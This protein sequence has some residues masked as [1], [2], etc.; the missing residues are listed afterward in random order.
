[1][2]DAVRWFVVLEILGV[3]FLPLTVWLLGS[4][5]DHGY[6]S[7]K[8]LGLLAVTYL[9]WL[10]GSFI[11]I[12][13][14]ALLPLVVVLVAAALGWWFWLDRT[15]DAVRPLRRVIAVE[16]AVFL[17]GFV[18]WCLLRAFVLH[19]GISHTEQPM[20]MALLNAS[21]H[22]ASYP[23]YDPWMSGHTINYYYLGYLLFAMPAK[24]SGVAPTVAYN[25]ALST[26]P[27][28]LMSSCYG[29][30]YAFVR[31]L[32][33]PLLAPLFVAVIGNWHAA[34]AQIPQGQTP[35]NT[36]WWFWCS[37]RV[38]GPS[39]DS[40]TTITEFPFFSFLLGDLHPHVMTLPL[41][42]LAITIGCAILFSEERIAVERRVQPLARLVCASVAV[43]IL[44]TANSWDFP[45]YLLFV[46]SCIV[47]N[48]YLHDDSTTWYQSA[49][50]SAAVLAVASVV[51]FA[52]FYLHY[53]SVTHGI[54]LVNTPSDFWQFLQ[55][56]GLFL[57]LAA[58]FVGILS[59]LLQPDDAS[60]EGED[61]SQT[62]ATAS[63]AGEARTWAASNGW[64]IVL[65]A[66]I[67]VLGV[68]FHLVVL[69]ALLGVGM[70]AVLLLY[71]VL[72]TETP[73]RGDACALLLVAAGCLAA[74][75]PEVVYLRD[76]FDG[77]A[78]YRMN[79]IFK[80]DYQAW[81]LLGLAA[82]YAVYR[83]WHIVRALF[84]PALGWLVLGCAMVGTIMGLAYTWIAPPTAYTA[85]AATSLDAL[86]SLSPHNPGD[87]DM[88][89]WLDAHA[90]PGAVEAEALG[91][92][93]HQNEEY[94]ADIGRIS[95]YTGLSAVLAWPGHER[96]WRGDD[97]E[98]TARE[99]DVNTIFSTKEVATAR[100][101][102]HK[103]NVRYV[104]VGDS[105]R[106]M[107]GSDPAALAKFSRFM[108][109]AY[110][111]SSLSQGSSSTDTIYTW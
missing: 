34:L 71:R 9:T 20:D 55:V 59:V 107:Y 11:P 4:L 74:A 28:L 60:S 48:A 65:F 57:I 93:Q 31:K 54:G 29:I 80:F 49:A 77:G 61:W 46:G 75:I 56:L 10:V 66:A 69:L 37:T 91:N 97:P 17:A 12:A 39:C 89:R 98:I 25:L 14:S 96:Q 44:F 42:A 64:S 51:L 104:I 23:A 81:V 21:I 79:T 16:E 105:E 95:F 47:I 84:A 43:G 53:R 73:N 100:R 106:T 58:A 7:T 27:A 24:L 32:H 85:G 15:I 3:V 92:A 62:S 8:I 35:T 76:V 109:V 26:V 78:N 52:P 38:I 5:P 2:I 101:L 19:P 1:M 102:L 99:A 88:V 103:Y 110:R 82:A 87:Y 67:V 50:A 86:A 6:A 72:N 90:S 13:S 111:T 22:A 70:V 36:T 18:G 41:T 108:R 30:V 68:R 40:Y 94:N 33:W 45:I 63:E 83:S